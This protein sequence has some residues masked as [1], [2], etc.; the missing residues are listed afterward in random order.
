MADLWG[1]GVSPSIPKAMFQAGKSSELSRYIYIFIYI[2][3]FPQMGDTP[4]A[5]WF[6]MENPSKNG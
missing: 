5:G 2:W 4:I 6:I 1:T 3:R